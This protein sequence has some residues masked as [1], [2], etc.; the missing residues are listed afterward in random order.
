MA[1]I[2]ESDTDR[3]VSIASQLPS[4]RFEQ[5][6]CR[7]AAYRREA[8][9]PSERESQLLLKISDGLPPDIWR[10]YGE[11]RARKE[12]GELTPDD[13]DQ[14]AVVVDRLENYMADRV[15]WLGE[16]AGLRNQSVTDLMTTLELESPH[17]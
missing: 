7:V 13:E 9:T 14:I 12:R 5:F 17:D 15:R 1:G 10:A 2:L 16:L 3:L 8:A 6:L 4:E 11:L